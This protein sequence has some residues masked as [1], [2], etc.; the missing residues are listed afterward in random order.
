MRLEVSIEGIEV[1]VASG[2]ESMRLEVSI[3]GIE[4]EVASGGESMRLEVS[5]E[6]IEVEVSSGGGVGI[7]VIISQAGKTIRGFTTLKGTRLSE[8]EFS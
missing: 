8:V 2:G 5:I 1:E 6:G 7:E 3:E 4:V